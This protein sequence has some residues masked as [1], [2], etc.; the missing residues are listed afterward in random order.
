MINILERQFD[1][2]ACDTQA[3]RLANGFDK[4]TIKK[5]KE[6]SSTFLKKRGEKLWITKL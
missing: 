3:G 6:R 5:I 2:S 1:L 4:L